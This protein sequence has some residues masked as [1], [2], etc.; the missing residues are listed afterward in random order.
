MPFPKYLGLYSLDL[1]ILLY[2]NS[3]LI[4]KKAKSQGLWWFLDGL[5]GRKG[6]WKK[7]AEVMR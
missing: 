1:D 5:W 7:R 4:C 3:A 6:S 2:E